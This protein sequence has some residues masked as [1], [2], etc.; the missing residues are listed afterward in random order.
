MGIE[1]ESGRKQAD[2]RI[3]L[4]ERPCSALARRGVTRVFSEGGPISAPRLI[5]Q[6]LADE[7]ILFTALKPLGR[8]GLPALSRSALARLATR[9]AM[10]RREIVRVGGDEMQRFERMEE[11]MGSR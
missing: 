10:R 9:G 5:G 7:V 4:G 8:P 6:G 3:D 11:I 1:V 2:G